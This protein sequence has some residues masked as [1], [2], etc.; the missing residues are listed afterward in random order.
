MVQDPGRHVTFECFLSFEGRKLCLEAR[1]VADCS[2]LL[3]SS[4]L[5][6]SY[7]HKILHVYFN[8]TDMIM[9]LT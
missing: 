1:L 7:P 2:S 8:L 4:V 6:L 3:S 9:T 5:C